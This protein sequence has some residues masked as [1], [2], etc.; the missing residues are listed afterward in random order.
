ME[1]QKTH[2]FR[3]IRNVLTRVQNHRILTWLEDNKQRA[4]EETAEEIAIHLTTELG[5]RIT[6][7]NIR[8][9]REELGIVRRKR[10]PEGQ[11][12]FGTTERAV[13]DDL[14]ERI[15][16]IRLEL[17]KQIQLSK[18]TSACIYSL[19]RHVLAMVHPGHK[20]EDARTK[21]LDRYLGI[22]VRMGVRQIE[23]D[24]DHE[25]TTTISKRVSL[26]S[27]PDSV[28]AHGELDER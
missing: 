1:E 16:L 21:K 12:E 15:D 4:R 19:L 22:L 14:V 24:N 28:Y 20:Y 2:K 5:F 9:C 17:N 11:L 25:N 26:F 8:H 7:S 13:Y 6:S 27:D 23:Y 18:E 3:K 10:R